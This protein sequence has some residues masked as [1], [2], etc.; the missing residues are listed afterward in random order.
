[1]GTLGNISGREAAKAFEKAG[2]WR[3]A[4]PEAI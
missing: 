4:R 1:V 2:G 3:V